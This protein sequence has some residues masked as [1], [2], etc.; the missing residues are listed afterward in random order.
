MGCPP[1]YPEEF[2]REEVALR[3]SSDRPSCTVAQDLGISTGRWR[4][5]RMGSPTAPIPR[6]STPSERAGVTPGSR[7]GWVWDHA[8]VVASKST[9]LR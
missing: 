3:R 9:G 4:R 8:T 7:T 6:S 5:G 2:R 1:K